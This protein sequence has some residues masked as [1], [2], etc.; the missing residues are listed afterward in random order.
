MSGVGVFIALANPPIFAQDAAATPKAKAAPVVE[1]PLAEA[2]PAESATKVEQAKEAKE[3]AAEAVKKETKAAE[4]KKDKAAEKSRVDEDIPL[5]VKRETPKPPKAKDTAKKPAENPVKPSVNK[6]AEKREAGDPETKRVDEDIPLPAKPATKKPVKKPVKKPTDTPVEERRADEDIPEKPVKKPVK[7]PVAKP[8]GGES[9]ETK[10]TDETIPDKPT[11]GTDEIGE[12][13]THP[14]PTDEETGWLDIFW[15][16]GVILHAKIP[17]FDTTL[18][19]GGKI[20]MDTG[21]ASGRQFTRDTGIHTDDRTILRRARPYVSGAIVDRFTFKFE[22]EF[23]GSG[24]SIRDAYLQWIDLPYVGDLTVGHIRQPA[25]LE[26]LTSSV[27]TM[28]AE[29]SLASALVSGRAMGVRI[30]DSAFEK[31]MTWQAGVFRAVNDDNFGSADAGDACSVGGRVTFL[32]VFQN[33]GETFLHLGASYNYQHPNSKVRYRSRPEAQFLSE[34]TNTGFFEANHIHLMGLEAAWVNGPF[35]VQGE[36][37]VAFL[38]TPESGNLTFDGFYVQASYLL[39]G[40]QRRYNRHL[41]VFLGVTPKENVLEK[42]PGAWEV[43]VRYSK[44]NLNDG[45]LP[46]SARNMQDFTVGV[47]WYLTRNARITGNYV[48]SCVKGSDT[49]DAVDIFLLRFQLAF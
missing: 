9:E 16:D 39:T 10:R 31:R 12:P 35:S 11:K 44:L 18:K 3:A 26:V 42:G 2:L 27:H 1:S 41:G 30:G 45:S 32:P 13:P 34:F 33:K 48:R 25:S 14:D 46:D 24:T 38:D 15:K 40:E 28:F 4:K 47:N 21:W 37:N 8:V 17:E 29:R 22:V 6:L 19:F 36:Y 20:M 49:S 23:A 7:K 5:G 43:A